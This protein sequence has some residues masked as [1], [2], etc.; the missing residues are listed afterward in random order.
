MEDLVPKIFT[1]LIFFL[2]SGQIYFAYLDK[3]LDRKTNLYILTK[4]SDNNSMANLLLVTTNKG[5]CNL[6]NY[7]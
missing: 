2:F 1:T 6:K 5:N 7:S 4:P 3:G